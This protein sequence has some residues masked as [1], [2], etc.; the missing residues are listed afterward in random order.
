LKRVLIIAIAGLLVSGFA[1]GQIVFYEQQP[2][3]TD[4]ANGASDLQGYYNVADDYYAEARTLLTDFHWY[5]STSQNT[6]NY[7]LYIQGWNVRIYDDAGGKPGGVLYSD[8]GIPA[9]NLPDTYVGIDGLGYYIFRTDYNLNTDFYFEAG[10]TYWLSTQCITTDWWWWQ[11][12]IDPYQV[13][14]LAKQDYDDGNW[15]DNG[16]GVDMS[17]QLTTVPEPG[18]ISLAGLVLGLGG[19]ALRKRV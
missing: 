7:D 4:S 17:F 6:M 3:L 10:R 16:T 1:Y 8:M 15:M 18:L 9:A 11:T 12:T 2:D 14:N 13:W 5:G 19:L